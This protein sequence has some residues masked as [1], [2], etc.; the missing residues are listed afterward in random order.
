M[1]TPVTLHEVLEARADAT[2]DRVAVSA[3]TGLSTYAQVRAQSL[4]LARWLVDQ[5]VRRGDRVVVVLPKDVL[6]PP[7]LY[8]CSRVGAMFAVLNERSPRVLVGHVL[9]DAAPAML[10]TDRSD[11]WTLATQRGIASAG[12]AEVADAA[13][14][15]PSRLD[16]PPPLLVDPACL[17]YT[18]GSTGMPRAVVSTQAQMTFTARAIQSQLNYRADDVVFCVLP[19]AFDYGLYQVILC[20]LSG[21]RLHLATEQD[22]GHRL[23][24]SLRAANASILPAV[25]SLAAGLA[26]MLGRRAEEPPAM[27]LLTS[28][29]ETMPGSTLAVLRRHMTTLTVQLMY[30]LTECKRATIMPADGDLKKPGACGLPLPGTEV[31]I[32]DERQ[33]PLPTGQIGEIFVRGP[34]V[35]AGYWRRPDQT[36]ERFVR[37]PGRTPGLRTG[38]FG[39][40]DDD[41]YLYFAG[42]RDDVYKERGYRTSVTEVEAA[43][44][45]IPLVESAG[46][47][48]PRPG[49][50][51]GATLFVVSPLPPADVLRRLADELDA[52][53]VPARC[54]RVPAIPLTANRKID[55]KAL[56]AMVPV[57]SDDD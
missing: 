27:R 15:Q 11:A 22:A 18:S 34:N 6:V 4:A 12:L 16:A 39:W 8:A 9:E 21:A 45:R 2:P 24:R 49:T 1:E 31:I 3:G 29:G 7:L 19:L 57:T 41:G 17:V 32:V 47:V 42:R 14:T 23:P 54:V 37:E 25:P 56:A 46:V 38:D 10:L 55:R 28:T 51:T 5:G 26:T 13:T 36:A 33:R 40:L 43:V 52:S 50:A 48:P 44:R 53:K 30:G 20:T 35:M